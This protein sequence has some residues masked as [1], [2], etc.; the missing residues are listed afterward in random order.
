MNKKYENITMYQFDLMK[1]AIGLD[2]TRKPERGKY[3]A[4]RNYFCTRGK[5]ENWEELVKCGV[6]GFNI[7]TPNIY[8]HVSDEG[9][10]FM[11]SVLGFKIK[12]SD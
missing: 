3:E 8:Y 11:E 12:E 4:Y 1:H 2:G 9:L 7:Q 5:D 10:R 6:A